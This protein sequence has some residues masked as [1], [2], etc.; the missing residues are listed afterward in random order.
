MQE[1]VCQTDIHSA[2]AL[3][4][5]LIKGC[6][7]G[8]AVECANAMLSTWPGQHHIHEVVEVLHREIS[9]FIS[10]ELWFLNSP[11]HN[12]DDCQIWAT[13]QECVCQTDIH[14]ADALKQ[15]LIKGSGAI[16]TRTLSTRLLT[17]GVKH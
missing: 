10:L 17:N 13:M 4:Q 11:D 14:S 9:N 5:R 6:L 3:K 16:L 15:R 7:F 1:Y 12:S 2:N 8:L